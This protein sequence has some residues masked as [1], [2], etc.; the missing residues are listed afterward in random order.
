METRESTVACSPLA[1]HQ[2]SDNQWLVSVNL[3]W[4]NFSTFHCYVK[5]NSLQTCKIA[6]SKARKHPPASV[7]SERQ[8]LVVEALLHHA[9]DLVLR[10]DLAALQALQTEQRDGRD[11]KRLAGRRVEKKFRGL[12]RKRGSARRRTGWRVGGG[13]LLSPWARPWRIEGWSWAHSP[14]WLDL[15]NGLQ[16]RRAPPRRTVC[17]R[18]APSWNEK[19]NIN[20]SCFNDA[21]ASLMPSQLLGSTETS[22]K[23]FTS[24]QTLG[25]IWLAVFRRVLPGSGQ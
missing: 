6:P 12:R 24:P 16:I 4:M 8:D 7:D 17:H 2:G 20:F 23:R 21:R 9:E 14:Y 10:C 19:R 13:L 18:R 3:H 1:D 5:V 15:G 11:R 25:R 22:L